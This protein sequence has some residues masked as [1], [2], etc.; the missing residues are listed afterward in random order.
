MTPEGATFYVTLEPCS[1]YGRTPPC[2]LRLIKEKAARV[3]VGT[4]DPNPLVA[5]RG[6][7]MLV[8]PSQRAFVKPKRL[9]P[10]S[11]LSPA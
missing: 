1:H 6:I 5:G 10:T 4:T 7:A 8:L 11:A 3:V 9:N 2:A